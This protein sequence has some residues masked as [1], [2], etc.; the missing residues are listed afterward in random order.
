MPTS[1]VQVKFIIG[2]PRRAH[3]RR[4]ALEKETFNDLVVLDMSENMNRGK[5]HAYFRWA[6][7][8]A[9]VPF[10]RAVERGQ[11]KQQQQLQQESLLAERALHGNG[12]GQTREV[13]E[14]W[15][16]RRNATKCCG[17][18]PTTW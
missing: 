1:N 4:V 16:S 9:T 12:H 11:Q 5:T 15:Q 8:N 2:K 3:A 6:A 18:K 14:A 13:L 7:E 10:L 17:R